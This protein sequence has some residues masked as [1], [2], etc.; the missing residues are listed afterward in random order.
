[1]YVLSNQFEYVLCLEL[2]CKHISEVLLSCYVL[3]G[4]WP[5]KH[6]YQIWCRVNFFL[7]VSVEWRGRTDNLRVKTEGNEQIS[8]CALFLRIW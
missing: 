2:D 3:N 7:S 5:G 8:F 6:I 4:A 1:M